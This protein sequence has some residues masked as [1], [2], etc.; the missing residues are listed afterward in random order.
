VLEHNALFSIPLLAQAA[1]LAPPTLPAEATRLER[2]SE[3]SNHLSSDGL[4]P[5]NW[6][7]IA[8]GALLLLVSGMSIARWWQHRGE[9]THPLLIF[10]RIAGM[11]GLGYRDQWLLL[12]IAHR[13]SLASPLTL[14]LSPATYESYVK[15]Y[16]DSKPKWH[17]SGMPQRAKAIRSTLFADL[18]PADR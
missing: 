16:L 18:T 14:L 9:N 17:L 13:C 8:V 1:P 15:A 7:L 4:I 12:R 5:T 2:L 3:V 10:T 11:V 6:L